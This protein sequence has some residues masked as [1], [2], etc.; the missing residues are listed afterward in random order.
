MVD[1]DIAALGRSVVPHIT[2]HNVGSKMHNTYGARSMGIQEAKPGVE[3]LPANTQAEC[4][5]AAVRI[6]HAAEQA[7]LPCSGVFMGYIADANGEQ[8]VKIAEIRAALKTGIDAGADVWLSK[9]GNKI[10][11]GTNMTGKKRA[12]A[13]RQKAPVTKGESAAMAAFLKG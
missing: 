7:K 2:N 11:V 6:I 5:E 4:I 12:S 3:G 1:F 9:R 10:A 13:P 8:P